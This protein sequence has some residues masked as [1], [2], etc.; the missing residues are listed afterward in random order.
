MIEKIAKEARKITD[1][2]GIYC[3]SAFAN[4]A[5]LKES[6]APLVALEEFRL[7]PGAGLEERED[8]EVELIYYVVDGELT[9]EYEPTQ[10]DGENQGDDRSASQ[11]TV[12]GAGDVQVTSTGTRLRHR[13]INNSDGDVHFV[14]ASIAPYF[15]KYSPT[16]VRK[17]FSDEDLKSTGG[18][19]SAFGAG[20]AFGVVTSTYAEYTS[21]IVR[22]RGRSFLAYLCQGECTEFEPRY[23]YQYWLQVISGEVTVNDEALC[24]GDGARIAE[25]KQIR[26]SGS[27]DAGLLLLEIPVG[28]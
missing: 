14:R 8:H 22:Q 5:A 18:A 26:I 19:D 2:N 23:G 28:D 16:V 1:S 20:K 17:S 3:A 9:Q 13:V 10:E 7:A 11:C 15:D 4:N 21:M 12:T 24:A 25:E 27:S 6:L